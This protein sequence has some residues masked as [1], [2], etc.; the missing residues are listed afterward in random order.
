MYPPFNIVSQN[1]TNFI[2]TCGEWG[3]RLGL[4]GYFTPAPHGEVPGQHLRGLLPAIQGPRRLP[5]VQV[6]RTTVIHWMVWL[7]TPVDI[8]FKSTRC[9][10][11]ISQSAAELFYTDRHCLWPFFLLPRSD[12]YTSDFFVGC[13][14]VMMVGMDTRVQAA[15]FVELLNSYQTSGILWSWDE[16]RGWWSSR[17]PR[18]GL[19][20]A[21]ESRIW[22]RGWPLFIP[23]GG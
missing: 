5:H 18:L 17:A 2:L 22:Q 8:L 15:R 11:S 13:M 14:E 3:E 19:E 1:Y 7:L 10:S 23:R 6:S 4:Q 20:Y 9:F 21:K 16:Q 12:C